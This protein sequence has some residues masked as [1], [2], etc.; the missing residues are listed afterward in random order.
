M[1]IERNILHYNVWNKRIDHDLS[2]LIQP[3]EFREFSKPVLEADYTGTVS[4]DDTVFF[5][6]TSSMPRYKFSNYCE[7][8]KT[9]RVIHLEK[10]TAVVVNKEKLLAAVKDNIVNR[11]ATSYLSIP[12]HTFITFQGV[13]M[14]M[15]NLHENDPVY[16]TI[17]DYNEI[18][19]I[20]PIPDPSAF[21]TV[22]LVNCPAYY[23]A[24]IKD[25]LKSMAVMKTILDSK[26]KLIDDDA[27]NKQISKD[28]III[29]ASNY[30]ELDA[31][32]KSTDI[33]NQRTALEIM[34][35]SNYDASIFYISL[36]LNGNQHNVGNLIKTS[37][38]LKN[39]AEFF[40]N[41]N[42]NSNIPNFLTGMRKQLLAKDAMIPEYDEYIQK[43][44]VNYVNNVVS[45]AHVYVESVK[46]K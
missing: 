3:T 16:L 26:V 7:G 40:R 31:M 14:P 35:N 45:H 15:G 37:V 8:K 34:A 20:A 5:H 28:S 24:S 12:W 27:L 39:F 30:T 46:Y 33:G 44:Y 38:N 6:T 23:S 32:L 42:W 18:R 43:G 1:I 36:L 22:P 9:R 17:K 10:A 19:K 4:D 13:K 25:T 11:T 2:I 21:G 29:D 41:V